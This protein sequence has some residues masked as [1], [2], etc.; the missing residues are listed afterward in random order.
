MTMLRRFWTAAVCAGVLAAPTALAQV[1]FDQAV[2]V[3][4]FDDDGGDAAMDSS[5]TGL[6]GELMGDP[7]WVDGK[8]DGALNLDG[9]GDY[10][11][12]PDHASPR[13]GLTVTAWVKS[14]TAA[15]NTSGA[16]V[17]K[18]N[19]FIMHPNAGGTAVAF[20]VCNG[21][22]WNQPGG[23]ND[24][25]FAVDDITVWRSYAGTFDS[26]TGDWKIYVD[27]EAVSEMN[28]NN[29]PLT[30]HTGAMNIGFD[31]CCGGGR[32]LDAA[33]DEVG[34]FG[35]A[36]SEAEIQQIADTGLT[37]QLLAVNP[38]GKAP[39]AWASMKSRALR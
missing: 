30:E 26:A 11:R 5:G 16:M 28:I 6:D 8:F 3:W 36:M 33:F 39:T 24:G 7:E 19:Q 38:K 23:W 4:L 20:P 31:D 17:G 13:E 35:Y 18:R 22:C 9:V 12:I 34:V 2:G 1:D 25:N 32:Y 15:W 21:G 27:G 10:I 37:G 29:T 14:N